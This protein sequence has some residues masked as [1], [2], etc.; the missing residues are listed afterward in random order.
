MAAETVENSYLKQVEKHY[1][2]HNFFKNKIPKA[3]NPS[4]ISSSKTTPS[5]HSQT[6]P[7]TE[8]FPNRST[9]WE[10]SIQ[11]HG[12]MGTILLKP[13]K[14][15]PLS[16]KEEK[17]K[18]LTVACNLHLCCF[19]FDSVFSLQDLGKYTAS[20]N[21]CKSG[22]IRLP[23]CRWQCW[24][25]DCHCASWVVFPASGCNSASVSRYLVTHLMG[26]D[27]NNIVKCQKLTDDH[28]QFLIYQILRGLKVQ[29]I[30]VSA[31]WGNVFSLLSCPVRT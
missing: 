27:L 23:T 5:N 11:I 15:R 14:W 16:R 30:A 17:A 9:N 2:G 29:A 4:E 1:E 12:P 22:E 20:R 3:L 19:L 21:G 13:P 7:P 26:A 25:F 28:V 8:P 18:L 10:L 31:M 24:S 6:G